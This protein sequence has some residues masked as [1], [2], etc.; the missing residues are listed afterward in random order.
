MKMNWGDLDTAYKSALRFCSEPTDVD[1]VDWGSWNSAWTRLNNHIWQI[2]R[3]SKVSSW[4]EVDRETDFSKT[5][6]WPECQRYGTKGQWYDVPENKDYL[7]KIWDSHLPNGTIRFFNTVLEKHEIRLAEKVDQGKVRTITPVATPHVQSSRRLYQDILERLNRKPLHSYTAHG[8]NPYRGGVNALFTYLTGD[9]G[10]RKGFEFDVSKMD[11]TIHIRIMERL[12]QGEFECLRQEDRTGDNFVRM[13]NLKHQVYCGPIVMPDGLVLLKGSSGKGANTSGQFLTAWDNTRTAIFYIMYAFARKFGNLDEFDQLVRLVVLGDD[14]IMSVH[15][16]I[17]DQFNGD[18]IMSVLFSDLGVTLETPDPRPRWVYDL[19]FLAFGFRFD[20]DLETFVHVLDPQRVTSSLIQGGSDN[21]ETGRMTPHGFL[22]RLCGI[23]VASWG[24][25][26]IREMVVQC[27]EWWLEENKQLDSTANTLWEAAKKSYHNDFTLAQ[28][29]SGREAGACPAPSQ[30]DNFANEFDFLWKDKIYYGQSKTILPSKLAQRALGKEGANLPKYFDKAVNYVAQPIADA[31]HFVDHN[32]GHP[33]KRA[34]ETLFEHFG[35]SPL[36]SPTHQPTMPRRSRKPSRKPKRSASR[37]S[38]KGRSRKGSRKGS[39]K[40]SASSVKKAVRSELKSRGV[41]M[42]PK[43]NGG[44]TFMNFTR[45]RFNKQVRNRPGRIRIRGSEWIGTIYGGTTGGSIASPFLAGAQSNKGTLLLKLVMNPQS[46]GSRRL[47]AQTGFYEKYRFN[48]GRV[49]LKGRAASNIEGSVIGA[50]D[51]DPED[52]IGIGNAAYRNMTSQPG[53]RSYAY[54]EGT[55][56][57][58]MPHGSN[59]TAG[60]NGFYVD[61]HSSSDLRFVNQNV[62]NMAVEMPVVNTISADVG[63]TNTDEIAEVWIDYD[64]DFWLPD[65]KAGAGVPTSEAYAF[66]LSSNQRAIWNAD[67]SGSVFGQGSIAEKN[68]NCTIDTQFSPPP[69]GLFFLSDSLSD[70]HDILWFPA[71]W[72]AAIVY[73]LTISSTAGH[74]F[75]TTI[76]TDHNSATYGSD[77]GTNYNVSPSLVNVT[78]NNQGGSY[79]IVYRTTAENVP[80]GISLSTATGSSS[81]LSLAATIVAPL[82]L[83]SFTLKKSRM[84]DAMKA[85][86]LL[87]K[88]G[89]KID[90]KEEAPPSLSLTAG[91]DNSESES[92]DEHE[93]KQRKRQQLVSMVQKGTDRKY[94]SLQDSSEPV[95]KPRRAGT[96]F[97]DERDRLIGDQ[98]LSLLPQRPIERPQGARV[99]QNAGSACEPEFIL[100]EHEYNDFQQWKKQRESGRQQAG[101]DTAAAAQTAAAAGSSAPAE[102]GAPKRSSLKGSN[103]SG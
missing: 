62:F 66:Y 14:I 83:P 73:V 78:A 70:F 49:W 28:L 45:P 101:A 89:I 44:R 22:Q 75:L 79:A 67:Q 85:L 8:F 24:D 100:A 59:G 29:Y 90:M 33:G 84:A 27:I 32:L 5:N 35:G 37:K 103:S 42:R 40:R 21:K 68:N 47:Q 91:G 98:E 97:A 63:C 46:I 30:L 61:E 1:D 93:R 76:T 20:K 56:G 31:V 23:R 82:L 96:R 74:N 26:E 60:D 53:K 9:E 41:T 10:F 16:S 13:M 77:L 99:Q 3:G 19:R 92:D 87:R 4:E 81:S 38:R 11:S 2:C 71:E 57:W 50:W 88:S 80:W 43:T 48:D 54:S 7:A 6:G 39:R 25:P 51:L 102:P 55:K 15:D 72:T 17:I 52:D 18:W 12:L 95:D 34:F 86:K 64:I 36:K 94:Q 69:D 65:T 58:R